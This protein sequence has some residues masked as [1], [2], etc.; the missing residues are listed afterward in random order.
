MSDIDKVMHFQKGLLTDIK[1][2]VKLRQFRTTTE[3]I[4]FA[5]MYD[6][7][8]FVSSR[9]L[10]RTGHQSSQRRSSPQLRQRIE[11]QPTPME[12]GNA[13]IISREECMRRNLCL[14]CKEPGHRLADCRK[15]Q[16]RNSSR[17]PSRPP[18]GRSSFR[19]NQN[20][21]RRVV[22][23]EDDPDGEEDFVDDNDNHVEVTDSLQLNMVS[24]DSGAPSKRELRRFEGMMNDQVVRVLIDSGAERNIVRPGLAQHFVDAAKVTVERFDGTTTPARTAHRC[25]ETLIFD[26]RDFADV[27]LIEWEVSSNQDVILGHPWLVQFNLIINWQTGVMRFPRP[28][29]VLD[30][31][32]INDS[33]D[34]APPTVAAVEVT[35]ELLQHP[36]LSN[37]R[38]Q[39]DDHVK[40]GYFHMSLGPSSIA[41]LGCRPSPHGSG[42]DGDNEAAT[43]L[44]VI[45]AAQFATKVKAE[46]YV[47]LYHVTVKEPPKVKTV[48]PQF[49]AVVE[50]FADVFPAELPPGLPPQRSIEHEVIVKP[51]AEPS[52]RAPFR[53]P[54]IEQEALDIF[55]AELL[56]ENW[57]E[58]S[59]SPWVSNIFGVPK[60]DPTTGK[61]PSRLEWLHSNNPHMAIRWVIDYRLV[62]AA[63]E[64]AKIPLPHIEQLFDRMVGA[65]VFTILDLASGYH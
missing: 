47:E 14:Y 60:K 54:K 15:R 65:V 2:E 56:K 38:Q 45:S 62:N 49:Q 37:L 4:S 26:G 27:S 25:C 55:V 40:A 30:A 52:N 18:H 61:F 10:G 31:R 13:R 59:D 46:E 8:H 3:A 36:L 44:C 20:S 51:G 29:L 42:K 23:A 39:L 32:S 17:G 35:S 24:V 7:T 1:Q 6:R 11:E 21:F 41:S 34:V 9:Q 19:A 12:I 48:P 63:S 50:E 43:S 16:A 5:L 57:I 64:V 22:E 33:L 58:V 28:R 53:L